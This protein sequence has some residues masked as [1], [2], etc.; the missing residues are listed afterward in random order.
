VEIIV[1]GG[2][3]SAYPEDYRREFIKTIFDTCNGRVSTSLTKAQE[4]N[5]KSR[6]RIVGM[7]VE[8]RP[9][10]IT[11]AEVRLFREMGVTKVQVG[12][13]AF[14]EKILKRIRR[15]H[16]LEA[17][18]KATQMLKDA[19]FKV[20]YHFMPNLPGSTPRKDIA[21]AR[22]MYS[23]IRFRPDYVK[24]YPCMII[25]GT[26]LH[27]EYLAG[28]FVP[29]PDEK[30]KA[31]LKE[32]AALSP[33]WVRVD[34]LVR[35]IS[36]K[37][38]VGGM[39]RTN[40]RQDIELELT[41]EGR[42]CNC[43]RCREVRGRSLETPKL[44]RH[45]YQTRGGVEMFLEFIAGNKLYSLLRLRLPQGGS[46]IFP[47]LKGAAIIREVHTFG[48][49]LEVNT[50]NQKQAQHQG[51]GRQ[52]IAETERISKK[53]GYKKLAVISAVGTRE[54]YR[55]FGFTVEGLYMTKSL[56]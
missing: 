3:F 46:D 18:A 38:V 45:R 50:H 19:G 10:W 9:D 47:E 36:K 34:R 14:D 35:D 22:K 31:A 25:P 21:M 13:Q 40:L 48:T 42:P 39:L 33:R 55:K 15:G 37:W 56:D 24:I 28:E 52:L 2:T 54:Y 16:S 1:I 6:H 44:V 41:R 20:C 17:V 12:V 26:E 51:L 4:L 5:E 49:A 32:V 7:S 43:I 27:R 29:Y 23:D 11:P 30:L 53:A 8:T